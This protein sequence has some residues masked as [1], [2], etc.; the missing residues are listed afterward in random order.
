MWSVI[1]ASALAIAGI[2][3][4]VDCSSLGNVSSR[5][6]SWRLFVWLLRQL[7][8]AVRLKAQLR[9]AKSKKLHLRKDCGC[10]CVINKYGS[11]PLNNLL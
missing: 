7:Y 8:T 4:T 10:V 6:S 3:L 9:T 5:N 1:A 2:A 11:L